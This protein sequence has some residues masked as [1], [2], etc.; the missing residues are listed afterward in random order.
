S[1]AAVVSLHGVSFGCGVVAGKGSAW[2]DVKKPRLQPGG[3]DSFNR[4]VGRLYQSG[5]NCAAHSA[6]YFRINYRKLSAVMVFWVFLYFF[7]K[8][9]RL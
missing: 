2:A 4:S 7:R 8:T 3:F 1:D 6:I 9:Y 5:A